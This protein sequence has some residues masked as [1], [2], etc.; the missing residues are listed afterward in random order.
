MRYLK[1][2]LSFEQQAE[3]LIGRGLIVRDK[4]LLV[5][6]LQSVNYYRLSGYWYPFKIN[7]P[8]DGAEK[9]QQGTTFEMIWRRY[10]FDRR[11][12]LLVM[13][14]LEA[15]EVAVLR[16]QM[17]EQFT[18]LHGAF[19]YINPSHFH[20]TLRPE[21]HSK[22]LDELATTI[23]KSREEFVGRFKKN[24][25]MRLICPFGWLPN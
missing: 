4:Y 16:T 17:V 25:L 22:L 9:F 14:A 21:R 15:M 3:R 19:G 6:R 7:D 20:A 2:A 24:M 5:E 12:K 13:E 11:L 8:A 18:L 1:P 23:S 10:V